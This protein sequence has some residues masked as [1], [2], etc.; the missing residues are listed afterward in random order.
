MLKKLLDNVHENVQK[1]S[2][3][4]PFWLYFHYGILN[5]SPSLIPTAV[6]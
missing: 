5:L 1:Q 3:S 4:K 2:I 6:S